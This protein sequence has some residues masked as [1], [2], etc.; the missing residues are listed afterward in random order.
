MIH[1]A[2]KALTVYWCLEVCLDCNAC[3][4]G[5]E[6]TITKLLGPFRDGP[7]PHQIL[8]NHHCSYG[9][10]THR[11]SVEV[12]PSEKKGHRKQTRKPETFNLRED[13]DG[14]TTIQDAQNAVATLALFKVVFKRLRSF[15]CPLSLWRR[16]QS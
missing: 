10:Y 11:Y 2:K 16:T 12:G 15:A 8:R 14:W 5:E 6:N 13:D 1:I 9:S 3:T 4:G 7:N